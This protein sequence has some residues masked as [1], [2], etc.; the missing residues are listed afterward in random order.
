MHD[1]LEKMVSNAGSVGSARSSLELPSSSSSRRSS[2]RV[3]GEDG[4][5]ILCGETVLPLDMSLATVRQYVW[6]QGGE[7]TMYYRRRLG[8]ADV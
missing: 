8:A 2:S 1:K 7:L 4:Y 5:E 3:R 6:R